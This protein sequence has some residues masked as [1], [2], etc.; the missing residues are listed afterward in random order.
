MIQKDDF[1]RCSN[2]PSILADLVRNEKVQT[3]VLGAS[4]LGYVGT[5][6]SIEREGMRLPLSSTA[7]KIAFFANLKD[8]VRLL[9]S[10]GQ[11]YLVLGAPIDVNR[12]NPS[13][14]V[15]RGLTLRIPRISSSRYPPRS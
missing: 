6:L 5:E 10:L 2:M 4:W 9:Q 7:G 8:Y 13:K 1:A 14:M 3:V 12:F 11:G 15:T